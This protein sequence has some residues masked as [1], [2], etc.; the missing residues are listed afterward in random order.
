MGLV[1]RWLGRNEARPDVIA[2]LAAEYR[3]HA[4]L[5]MQLRGHAEQARYPQVARAL[6]DVAATEERHAAW[7]LDH[8]RR[9]GGRPPALA[10]AELGGR[11]QWERAVA[12]ARTARTLRRQLVERI[13]RWDP[14]EPEVASLFARIEQEDAAQLAVLDRIVMRSDPHAI[15]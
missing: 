7:I 14:A 11:N 8:L 9:R 2:D 3:A 13:A 10:P 12:L 6:R 4:E 5:A 15:D 1:A